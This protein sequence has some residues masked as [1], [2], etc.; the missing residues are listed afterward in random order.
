MGYK[1]IM[2]KY[3]DDGRKI[4]YAVPKNRYSIFLYRNKKPVF[5]IVCNDK[6]KLNSKV[7]ELL[8]ADS[9]LTKIMDYQ[10]VIV[11]YS[12]DYDEPVVI[13]FNNK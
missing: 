3:Y 6:E 5:K 10:T 7:N 12:S 1:P 13:E 4:E 2:H 9:S 11:V 8:D